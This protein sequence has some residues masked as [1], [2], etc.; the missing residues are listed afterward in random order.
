[1][2]NA[3]P[4]RQPFT[5]TAFSAARDSAISLASSIISLESSASEDSWTTS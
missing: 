2:Q 5:T 4:P 1:M 3:S